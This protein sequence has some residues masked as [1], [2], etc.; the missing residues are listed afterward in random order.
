MAKIHRRKL[1]DSHN[2]THAQEISRR[3]LE[4]KSREASDP[5]L[6][7]KARCRIAITLKRPLPRPPIDRYPPERLRAIRA[8]SHN[9]NGELRR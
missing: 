3:I 8:E 7:W 4:R 6:Q 1:P 9:F 2:L 5:L